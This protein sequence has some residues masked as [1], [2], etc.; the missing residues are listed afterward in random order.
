[1]I[2][3]YSAHSRISPV[4]YPPLLAR[5]TMF[6]SITLFGLGEAGAIFA[7]DLIAGGIE[8]VAYDPAPVPTPE[9]ARRSDDPREAARNA[10][11]VF[12]VTAAADAETALSQAL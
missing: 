4:E 12:A 7:R 2:T 5:S 6:K 8:V 3:S 11:A 1:M 9:G 10:E